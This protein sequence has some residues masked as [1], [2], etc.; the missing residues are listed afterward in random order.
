MSV[1]LCVCATILLHAFARFS[2]DD[3]HVSW[4]AQHFGRAQLHF[5][6]QAQHFI[7]ES[8]CVYLANRIVVRAA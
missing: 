4:Q 7:D 8:C 6:R 3:L 2:E 1:D 5:A